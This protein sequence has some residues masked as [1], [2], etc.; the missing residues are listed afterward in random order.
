M[1]PAVIPTAGDA[2]HR[3]GASHLAAC[4]APCKMRLSKE[5]DN[6]A[7]LAMKNLAN[8]KQRKTESK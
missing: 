6:L 8:E 5:V 7:E 4:L 2:R 1:P 3:P